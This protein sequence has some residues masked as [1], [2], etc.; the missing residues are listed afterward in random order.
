MTFF[1]QLLGRIQDKEQIIS[2]L[3]Q[4]NSNLSHA[5]SA[6]E[7]R[8]QELYADQ[9]RMEEEFATRLELVER[10]RAQLQETEREKRDLT[11]RYNEQV[12]PF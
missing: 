8:I 6:A 9:A 4:E 10:L 12:T 1:A 11:R 5:I 3:S 2:D 7:S